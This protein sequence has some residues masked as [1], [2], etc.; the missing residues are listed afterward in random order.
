MPGKPYATPPGAVPGAA[1]DTP[2]DDGPAQVTERES[3]PTRRVIGVL[4]LLA[5]HPRA[6]LSLTEVAARLDLSM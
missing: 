5:D 1:R 6:R 4:N 2:S 3:P